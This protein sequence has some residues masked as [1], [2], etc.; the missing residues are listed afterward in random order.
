[1]PLLWTNDDEFAFHQA[2]VNLEQCRGAPSSPNYVLRIEHEMQLANHIAFVSH[3]CEGPLEI[4]AVCIEEQPSQL[5]RTAQEEAICSPY[6]ASSETN[7]ALVPAPSHWGPKQKEKRTSLRHRT[8]IFSNPELRE[9]GASL[10]AIQS[11]SARLVAILEP[12]ESKEKPSNLLWHIKAAVQCCDDVSTGT[13]HKSL[14][15]QLKPMI[16]KFS[17]AGRKVVAQID[18]IA[19]Y[20]NMCRDLAKLYDTRASDYDSR[21]YV[22]KGR[23]PA[24][25]IGVKG[26]PST[27][28]CRKF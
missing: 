1:M 19:R 27:L 16:T 20:L 11:K 12:L 23:L 15:A 24:G 3:S 25:S 10:Y 9:H 21:V 7:A 4:T 26:M 2:V 17:E 28:I 22:E 5:W 8:I 6:L 13:G 18:K 14:E